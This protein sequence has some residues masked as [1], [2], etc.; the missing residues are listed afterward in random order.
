MTSFDSTF[1]NNNNNNNSL[2]KKIVVGGALALLLGVAT[3][4]SNGAMKNLLRSNQNKLNENDSN[5]YPTVSLV[6]SETKTHLQQLSTPS[7]L[8]VHQNENIVGVTLSATVGWN[9]AEGH[10]EVNLGKL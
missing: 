9:G 8:R 5:V 10:F 4:S 2:R 7:T 1:N 6:A 3:Y